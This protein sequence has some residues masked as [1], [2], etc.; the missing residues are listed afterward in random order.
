[1]TFLIHGHRQTVLD[2]MIRQRNMA[3]IKE[4]NKIT[5]TDLIKMEISNIPDRECKILIIK[6]HT[7][8]ETRVEDKQEPIRDTWVAEWLSISLQLRS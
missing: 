3:Q 6:I 2:K 4:Q 8:L 5:A 1:M 7:G